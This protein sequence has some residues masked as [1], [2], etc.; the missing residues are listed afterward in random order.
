M[1][2]EAF[3]APPLG[4]PE[5]LMEDDGGPPGLAGA[6]LGGRGGHA[7]AQAPAHGLRDRLLEEDEL[8]TH[9]ALRPAQTCALPSGASGIGG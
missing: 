5:R 3:E 9:L 8:A 1:L 2:A 4:D 6:A 7:A